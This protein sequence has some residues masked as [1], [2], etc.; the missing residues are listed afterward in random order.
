MV[1][2]AGHPGHRGLH[3]IRRVVGRGAN[4][5]Q[6]PRWWSW[7]LE[8]DRR[9]TWGLSIRCLPSITSWYFMHPGPSMTCSLG[10]KA[11]RTGMIPLSTETDMAKMMP[12]FGIPSSLIYWM[13]TTMAACFTNQ[14]MGHQYFFLVNVR[15]RHT[16]SPGIDKFN[17]FNFRL[18]P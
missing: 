7:L 14:P 10:T 4:L 15:I 12:R 5:N 17:Q 11:C 1:A 16:A 3:K 8:S 9:L 18:I 13:Y 2:F 6:I